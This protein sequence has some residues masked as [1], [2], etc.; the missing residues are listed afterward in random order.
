MGL[1]R[2]KEGKG[3]ARRLPSFCSSS[4][5]PSL[6]APTWGWDELQGGGL[7]VHAGG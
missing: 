2:A 5:E 6:G 1:S 7:V 3:G 4:T